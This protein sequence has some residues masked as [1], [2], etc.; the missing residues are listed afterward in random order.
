MKKAILIVLALIWIASLIILI[1][2]LTDLVKVNPF[3]NYR[4]IIGI[5][6]LTISGF[7]RKAYQNFNNPN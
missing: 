2:A 3:K 7:I 1:I 6:F 4:W 5:G